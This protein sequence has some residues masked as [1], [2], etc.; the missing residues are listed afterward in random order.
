MKP[1]PTLFQRLGIFGGKKDNPETLVEWPFFLILSAAFVFVYFQAVFSNA[2]LRVPERLILFT[3]LMAA[4]IALHWLSIRVLQWHRVGIY[5]VV[6]SVLAFAIVSLGGS[7]GPL[8][9]VY[10][11]L[12]G[13]TIGLLRGKPRWMYVAVAAILGLSLLNYFLQVS[14]TEWYWWFVAMLPMTFFVAVYVILYSRQAEARLQAQRLLGELET[15]NRQLTEYAA[16]VE[17]LTIAA[18]RQRMARELHDTLSQGLAGLILQLEAADAHLAANHPER[19]RSILEQSMEKARDTLREARQAIDALR[20]PAGGDLAEAIEK[21]AER[22]NQATGVACEPS[23]E[24]NEGVPETVSDT[25]IRVISEGLSNIAR[26]ARARNVTL[27]VSEVGGEMEIEIRDDGVGF[28]PQ[29]VQVG[30]Y[31]L[32]GMRERVRLAGGRLEVQSEA[33]K[34]TCI[35][36]HLPLDNEEL[37]AETGGEEAA[38][39]NREIRG[40]D[41]LH[42]EYPPG[43]LQSIQDRQAPKRALGTSSR[44]ERG[45]DGED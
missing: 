44:R 29:A 21:E 16:R 5:L 25:A 10:M 20:Q 1:S 43:A 18:E 39:N 24:L 45:P 2:A 41:L 30:H 23:I 19:A 7:I 36:I 15:A 17:D 13:E 38:G 8:L 31:G 40:E 11:G 34:G 35:L 6:Q 37:T 42:E 3:V 33:G 4:H 9:A 32:L 26:H 12:I 28:D 14:R 27:R 22:F